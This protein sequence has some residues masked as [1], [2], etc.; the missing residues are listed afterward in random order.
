MKLNDMAIVPKGEEY[1]L[2]SL[3]NPFIFKLNQEGLRELEKLLSLSSIEELN[4]PEL[5]FLHEQFKSFL[6]KGKGKLPIYDK[7][8]T[9]LTLELI[10]QC[11]LNCKHCYLGPKKNKVINLKKFKEIIDSSKKLGAFSLAMTGGEPFLDKEILDKIG[12]ARKNNF[13]VTINS[14]GTLINTD[15]AKILAEL[16]IAGIGFTLIGSQDEHEYIYGENTYQRTLNAIDAVKNAGITLNLN[17]IAYSGNIDRLDDILLGFTN[18]FEPASIAIA[19]IT[20][21]GNA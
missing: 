6:S 3:I 20:N 1:E 5:L 16:K 14:N 17:V 19:P 18:N 9:S 15:I 11:N 2:I 4:T 21:I 13:R 7:E 12:Y 10:E 8:F